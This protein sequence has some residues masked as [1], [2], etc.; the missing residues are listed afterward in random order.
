MILA[1]NSD[2]RM[3]RTNSGPYAGLD[4][5]TQPEWVRAWSETEP[6]MVS[7][8]HIHAESI[9]CNTRG[10]IIASEGILVTVWDLM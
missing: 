7:E 9:I 6:K 10:S 3:S 4:C 8:C 2:R 1:Y 5:S